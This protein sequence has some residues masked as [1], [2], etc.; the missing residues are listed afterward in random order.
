M[1]YE[2]ALSVIQEK[3][4]LAVHINNINFVGG[5]GP[6]SL[7]VN[8]LHLI[9]LHRDQ[10]GKYYLVERKLSVLNEAMGDVEFIWDWYADYRV[11]VTRPRYF[12]E[13]P[14]GGIAP[15]SRGTMT[16]DYSADAGNK[17]IGTW[18]DSAASA[19]GRWQTVSESGG[20][21]VRP[22]PAVATARDADRRVG[23]LWNSALRR[24]RVSQK[25][26]YLAERLRKS[27]AT[28][29]VAPTSSSQ[30]KGSGASNQPKRVGVCRRQSACSPARLV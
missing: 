26:K 13:L 11:A 5:T 7:G 17:R 29:V 30:Q 18:L 24:A 25:P 22:H 8:P 20:R 12:P 16:Y 9:G 14:I 15:L 6:D 28:D 2:T 21:M 23:G 4:L 27:V 1:R 19:V 3:G 10:T